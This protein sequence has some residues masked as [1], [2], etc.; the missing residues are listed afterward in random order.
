MDND[1]TSQT[2]EQLEKQGE[3]KM[4]KKIND[5]ISAPVL[6]HISLLLYVT[7]LHTR[8]VRVFYTTAMHIDTC[9]WKKEVHMLYTHI[10]S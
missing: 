4:A 8:T 7:Y 10:H 2:L 3:R 1:A 9:T 5:D 6:P